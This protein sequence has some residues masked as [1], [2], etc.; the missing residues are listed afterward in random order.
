MDNEKWF[1]VTVIIKQEQD[2][3]RI[4]KVPEKYLVQAFN[5]TD[6]EA[7]V[8]EDF[9]DDPMEFTIKSIADSKVIKIIK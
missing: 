2:S 3:G 9:K 8:N 5:F 4:K 1:L 6:A 7:K